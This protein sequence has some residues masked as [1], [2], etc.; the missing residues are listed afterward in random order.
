[1]SGS[2]FRLERIV[3]SERAPRLRRPAHAAALASGVAGLVL[4][5]AY[6]GRFAPVAGF[7]ALLLGGLFNRQSAVLVRSREAY[8]T[9]IAGIIAG[10]VVSSLSVGAFV[11][12]TVGISLMGAVFATAVEIIVNATVVVTLGLVGFVAAQL[13]STLGVVVRGR[14]GIVAFVA[15]TLGFVAVRLL[16]AALWPASPDG[17]LRYASVLAAA[18]AFTGFVSLHD[19]PER[20]RV[21]AAGLLVA[22][23]VLGAVGIAAIGADVGHAR[24]VADISDRASATVTDASVTDGDLVLTVRLDNPTDRAIEPTGLYVR[25]RNETEAS[26]VQGPGQPVGG[27]SPV[28][29]PGG[30]AT[31]SYRFPLAPDQADRVRAA[32]DDGVVVSGHMSLRLAEGGSALVDTAGGI[33]LDFRCSA[34]AD[35]VRC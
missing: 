18:V 17:T 29:E 2:P 20:R 34:T 23:V 5:M 22:G 8:G 16:P 1:M 33:R 35:D 9:A 4:G 27:E 7:V 12:A 10:G 13:L 28:V 26:L 25:A 3:G 31:V 21:A 24:T 32:L 15:G 11:S 6:G 14:G 30:T 19:A